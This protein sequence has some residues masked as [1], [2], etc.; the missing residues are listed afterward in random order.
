MSNT[1]VTP[2]KLTRAKLEALVWRHTHRDFKGLIDGA[3]TV[4][5]RA[6][7]GGTCLAWLSSLTDAELYDKLPSRVRAELPPEVRS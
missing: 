1:P 5:H 7:G 6:P 4:L 3:R 2:V